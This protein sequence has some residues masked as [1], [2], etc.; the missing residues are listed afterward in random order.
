VNSQQFALS[1]AQSTPVKH[2]PFSGLPRRTDIVFSPS[3]LPE[4][5]REL[6]AN[7][8]DAFAEYSLEEEDIQA[9]LETAMFDVNLAGEFLLANLTAVEPEEPTEPRADVF[10]DD[11][12]QKISEI[13]RVIAAERG[14]SLSQQERSDV[15]QFYKANEGNMEATLE[16]WRDIAVRDPLGS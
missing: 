3:D 11:D 14:K 9:A 13:V 4:N 10:S 15:I 1:R 5:Y 12:V 2:T 6:V 7:L 16:L 8:R